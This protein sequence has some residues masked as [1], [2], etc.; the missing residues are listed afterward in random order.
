M[1]L[2][3]KL[4]FSIALTI[5]AIAGAFSYIQSRHEETRLQNEL[6]RRSSLLSESLLESIKPLVERGAMDQVGRIIDKFS[7]RERLL[8]IVL[9]TPANEFAIASKN[10]F[11]KK[12]ALIHE[13]REGVQESAK[14]HLGYG[15]FLKFEKKF[16]HGYF[17]PIEK[18]EDVSQVLVILYDAGYIHERIMRMW[19]TG[20]LRALVQASSVSVIVLLLVYLNILSPIRRTVEWIKGVR[21]GDDTTSFKTEKMMAP[22]TREVSEMVKSLQMARLA[23]E[24]EARLRQSLESLWTPE[25]LKEFVRLKLGGR[26]LLVVSNREPYMHVQKGKEIECIVP[27]SGLVTAIEPVLKA[28]G[29]TWIA[30]GAGDADRTTV[31]A[32]Q[33]LRVPPAEPHYLLRRVWLSKEEEEGYY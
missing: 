9:V 16:L 12:D 17:V 33:R 6:E 24:E 1:R 8:G 18:E 23:A 10:L 26:P 29:G 27:A 15:R 7:N 19:L 22:L 3:L 21:R 30:H 11:E 4:V 13:F 32:N 25:R 20:F 14:T 2:F 5:L 31:D 28:C